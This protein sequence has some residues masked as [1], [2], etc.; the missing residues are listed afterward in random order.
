M[1]NVLENE[2]GLILL[3]KFTSISQTEQN[4][5]T[6]FVEPQVSGKEGRQKQ[7]NCDPKSVTQ[8][9]KALSGLWIA[10]SLE[11]GESTLL[12]NLEGLLVFIFVKD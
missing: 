3:P 12:N 4:P 5:K 9:M 11:V 8:L 2:D 10:S 1:L 7:N 6:K